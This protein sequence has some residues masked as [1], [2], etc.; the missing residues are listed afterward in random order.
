LSYGG[1]GI[2]DHTQ[3]LVT[4]TITT[5]FGFLQVLPNPATQSQC[6]PNPSASTQFFDSSSLQTKSQDPVCFSFPLHAKDL[7]SLSI[8]ATL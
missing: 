2:E 3:I 6:P 8:K 5:N 4:E 1:I 7:I